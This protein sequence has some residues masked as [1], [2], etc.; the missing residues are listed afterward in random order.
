MKI[1]KLRNAVLFA[2]G[3]SCLYSGFASAEIKFNGFGSVRGTYVNTDS[4]ERPFADLPKDGEISFKDESIFGL[5]ARA[6]LGDGLSATVQFVADGKDDFDV[7]ARWAYVSYKLDNHHT[8]NVGR[9]ANPIFYQSEYEIV[10]YAHDF[11]RLPKSVYFGFDFNNL[12]GISLDSNYEI[13]GYN[14]NT[15]LL[16]GTWDG[17]I[18]VVSTGVDESIGLDDVTLARVELSKDWW[19][20]FAGGFI[21]EFTE[22]SLNTFLRSAV[23]PG[24]AVALANGATP[25][26]VTELADLVQYQGKDGEYW[27]AGYN[28]D[29]KNFISNFEYAKYDIDNTLFGEVRAWY[30]SLGYRF[31]EYV[32]T[33]RREKMER[34]TNYSQVSSIEHPILNATGRGVHDVLTTGKIDGV[35]LTVRYDF[36]PSAAFKFDYFDAEDKTVTDGEYSILSMGIDV[37]F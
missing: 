13:G 11:A 36:H 28:I 27:Y 15:K 34:V 21:G 4:I 19:K 16:Y 6:D 1:N 31:D 17:T 5:Q 14:L 22:G 18:T 30:A 10:G 8:V 3:S 25:E 29:Y 9:F 23:A 7:E 24:S 32:V 12:E 26:Q 37:I 35:G 33:V 2:L 20:V